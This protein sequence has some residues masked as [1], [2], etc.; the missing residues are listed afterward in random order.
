MARG[1]TLALLTT[2]H[3]KF[4]NMVITLDGLVADFAAEKAAIQS[5]ITLV[6]SLF[7]QY[8]KALADLAA[9]VAANDPVAQAAAQDVVNNLDAQVKDQTA[10]LSKALTDNTPPT[11]PAAAP[12]A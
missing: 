9:A 11:A 12:A 7:A 4:D 2:L 6:T 1:I 5:L 10:A 8:N 3:R